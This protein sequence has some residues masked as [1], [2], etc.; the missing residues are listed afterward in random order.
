MKPRQLARRQ[1]VAR[2]G[3][4]PEGWRDVVRAEELATTA[5][6]VRALADALSDEDV[7]RG[8]CVFGGRDAIEASSVAFDSVTEL[9]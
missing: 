2:F 9:C 5:D 3:G 7:A 4:K 6:D 8:I 1:D